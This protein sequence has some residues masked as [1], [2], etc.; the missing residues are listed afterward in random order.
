MSFIVENDKSEIFDFDILN[1]DEEEN[2]FK[3]SSTSK[4]EII[5]VVFPFKEVDRS[6]EDN[7]MQVFFFH[8]NYLQA[9]ND[10]FQVYIDDYR[11]GWIFPI[12]S[13]LSEENNFSDNPYFNKYKYATYK[14]IL[15]N[16]CSQKRTTT[17]GENLYNLGDFFFEDII[18]L[19]ISSETL[20]E[21][22][23]VENFLPSFCNYGYY[24]HNNTPF[25]YTENN[26]KKS[27]IS[28]YKG[29]SKIKIISSKINIE[30]H[31]FIKNLYTS[32][33][34]R[35]DDTT[36]KFFLLYQVIEYLIEKE[37][38]IKFDKALE[39]Y[40]NTKL[41]KNNFREKINDYSK[42]RNIIR[43]FTND[44]PLPD[45]LKT[46]LSRDLKLLLDELIINY[47]KEDIGDLIYDLRNILI[48]R[49]RDIDI[50]EPEKF[51][52]FDLITHQMELAINHYLIYYCR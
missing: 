25:I 46:D 7:V 16:K 35:T 15:K 12:Q 31:N 28:E 20:K 10:V 14:E 4:D 32:H 29:R 1:F 37:F 8:N 44:F 24:L 40:I 13:I 45:K 52:L 18:I 17:F 11:I 23:L 49:Y 42:E 9:E 43:S 6:F 5:N 22:F 50:L 3:L 30:E 19:C 2:I 41:D 48:H 33:L 34:K 39:D 36:L 27:L 38:N 26:N 47:E 51:N 21:D